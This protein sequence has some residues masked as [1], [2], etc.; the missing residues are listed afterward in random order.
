MFYRFA[1]EQV[2]SLDPNSVITH[3]TFCPDTKIIMLFTC[4]GVATA[5]TANCSD[6]AAWV[7]FIRECPRLIDH[8]QEQE[9]NHA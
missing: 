6:Y 5:I 8:L 2:I 1:D 4:T 7:Q 9:Q 3:M